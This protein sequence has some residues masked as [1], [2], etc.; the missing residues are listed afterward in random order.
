MQNHCEKL[1]KMLTNLSSNMKSANFD[2]FNISVQEKTDLKARILLETDMMKEVLYEH[3]AYSLWPKL[4]NGEVLWECFAENLIM[5]DWQPHPGGILALS[6]NRIFLNGKLLEDYNGERIERV[7]P[8]E[9]DCQ[10][11]PKGYIVTIGPDVWINGEEQNV[12][13]EYE[14]WSE[15]ETSR[16]RGVASHPQGYLR[17]EIDFTNRDEPCI[18]FLNDLEKIEVHGMPGS[19]LDFWV[20]RHGTIWAQTLATIG[21]LGNTVKALYSSKAGLVCRESTPSMALGGADILPHPDGYLLVKDG[22][23]MLNGKKTIF[24]INSLA[25]W[26]YASYPGG[27]VDKEIFWDDEGQQKVRF[28]FHDGS[29]YPENKPKKSMFEGFMKKN[30]K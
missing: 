23:I 12:D 28:V 17:N 1:T 2:S 14:K 15:I 21:F 27:I 25:V 8:P 10:I 13:F 26:D 5:S 18:F 24:K 20:D 16:S 3:D 4:K 9:I 19:I 6:N 30:K 7:E 11:H 29:E 22:K